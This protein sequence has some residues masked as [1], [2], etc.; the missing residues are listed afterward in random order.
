M[1]NIKYIASIC[2][3]ALLVFACSNDD[4][5]A[6]FVNS[7]VAPSNVSA[8]FN[9]TQDN[10]GLVTITPTGQG[11]VAFDIHFGDATEEPITLTAGES[12]EHIYDEGTYNV[13]VVAYNITGLE[14]EV[15]QSLVVSFNPPENLMVTIEND[16]AV[17]KQVN[18]TATADFGITYDVYFGEPGN[19][20]PVSGNMGETV[21][22]VYQEAGT[23]TI[24]VVAMSAAIETTTYTEEFTVT[25]I[26]QPINP[27]PAQPSRYE[28]DY[29]SIF[30][31]AYTNV[32]GT[33][34]NPD[35]GQSGQ[36]SSYAMFNLNGDDMLQYINL[37]YQGIQFGETVDAS[38]ME[39]LHIDVWTADVDQI[40]IFPISLAT[41]EQQVTQDLT[42][43][44]W[45]SFDI[46][47]SAFTDQGLS[48]ADLHQFKFVGEPWAAGSV[49]IDNLY[50][51][52]APAAASGIEGIWQLAPEA[53]ALMVGPS[54]GNG[55][56]WSND[57]QVVADRAC[58]FDDKYVFS[59][60]GTFNNVLDGETWIEPWQGMDPEACGAPVAPHDGSNPATF[61]YNEGDSTLTLNGTGAY[62]GLPKANNDGELPNVAVPSS[63]TYDITLLD[64][65]NTMIVS[66]EAG[67]GVFWTYKLVRYI[68][69]IVGSWQL[70]PEAGSLMVGPSPG[71][72]DWWS[73]DDQG[74]ADRA[75]YYDDVY[76][77]TSDGSFSNILGDETWVEGWQGAD[78][79]GCGAPVA[80]HDGSGTASYG[81][82]ETAGT[83]T[84]NGSGAYL[85]LPKANN[86]GELP[87]V[88]VPDAITYSVTLTDNDMTMTVSIEAGAGV[89]WTY[90][91]I[92]Q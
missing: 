1:K 30:A 49:F 63:I 46:P 81:Y 84:L 7:A 70:A 37:S 78:P 12:V 31:G 14:T 38:Q 36:G 51:W 82:N 44:Q 42:P 64:N 91:L 16:L 5:N 22:Y 45:N 34:Y 50:F 66:I 41:G 47:L 4:D 11:A 69:P 26:L 61:T 86:S 73:I 85:G 40:Q 17:S 19:D 89:F 52:K 6:D 72:G 9:V 54:P 18:V 10:T 80:P 75:C 15:T 90:K 3:I 39:Y 79:E 35:W 67:S 33:D 2:L 92:K 20:D 58:F 76:L 60:G 48:I 23:Y 83:L 55:D 65:N 21:S 87:N 8:A 62:L 13:Q 29:I 25:E 74:V 43:D 59:L 77:F 68:S 24:T 32:A 28:S 27:A 57:A 88:A 53:G 71:N 56:W